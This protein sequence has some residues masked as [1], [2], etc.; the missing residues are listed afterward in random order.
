MTDRWYSCWTQRLTV[1][2][3]QGGSLQYAWVWVYCIHCDTRSI[4][5]VMAWLSSHCTSYPDVVPTSHVSLRLQS[6]TGRPHFTMVYSDS[7]WEIEKYDKAQHVG[8][9]RYL[10][11]NLS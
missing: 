5:L 1:L 10:L 7:F 2:E 6:R 8:Q 9:P 3:H 4:I 11:K